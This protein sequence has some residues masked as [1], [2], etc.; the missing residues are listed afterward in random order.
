MVIMTN[1]RDPFFAFSK[2]VGYVRCIIFGHPN[3]D[4]KENTPTKDKDKTT[5]SWDMAYGIIFS[6]VAFIVFAGS[7]VLGVMGPSLIDIGNTAPVRPS[8]ARY[9][10]SPTGPEMILQRFGLLAPAAMRALGSVEA[11]QVTLRSRVNIIQDTSLGTDPQ[12]GEPIYELRYTYELSGVELGL[13]Y[14]A[15]ISLAV[16]GSCR[17]QYGW[18]VTGGNQSDE[19]DLYN[20][21]GVQSVPISIG[22]RDIRYAPRASFRPHPEM[23]ETSGSNYLFAILVSSARRSSIT[24]GSD[25]WYATEPRPTPDMRYNA[26]HWMKRHRPVLDCQQRDTWTHRG[27]TLNSIYD[28]AKA[29]GLRLA[30]SI[31]RVLELAFTTP[32]VVNLGNAAGE[33]ALR[34][35][36]T[37][38]N[39][40]IDA[41]E[42]TMY[43]DMERLLLAA[44]V[45]S[46]STLTDAAMF[47][48]FGKYPNVFMAGTADPKPGAEDFV[49]SSPGI[50]TFSLAGLIAL[51]LVLLF[52]IMVRG[53]LGLVIKLKLKHK[54]ATEKL[55]NDKTRTKATRW[56]R[57]YSFT[58]P[59]L[60]RAIY[61]GGT[62]QPKDNHETTSRVSVIIQDN[63][64]NESVNKNESNWECP[65][66][67]PLSGLLSSGQ[68]ICVKRHCKGHFDKGSKE[69]LKGESATKP[70]QQSTGSVGNSVGS[71]EN[72]LGNAI[73]D[74]DEVVPSP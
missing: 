3:N 67:V 25:P 66:P 35:R 73:V 52:L 70:K 53:V 15:D 18:S 20:L 12:S 26:T 4:Q 14:G 61:E 33:S 59:S 13:R 64:H 29:P 41:K 17:T 65:D 11:A 39:G 54:L 50:Q 43:S 31:V 34:S 49:V 5:E 55:K 8:Q 27:Q 68:Y 56:A 47:P 22:D 42:S 37:S 30:L 60:L 28:L 38:P 1:A 36:T 74:Q 63:N 40:V 72:K 32:A 48:D 21:W 2:M 16:S 58:A 23:V 9:P 62:K 46:R 24:P 45:A 69:E 44:F 51:P 71:G 19:V 57:P 10:E 6:L 7:T